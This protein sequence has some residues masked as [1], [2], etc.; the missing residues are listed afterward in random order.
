MKDFLRRRVLHNFGIKLLSLAL[1]VGLLRVDA[2][3]AGAAWMSLL[4]LV[5]ALIG[6][7]IGQML[8]R[9]IASSIFRRVFFAGL[10]LL[11]LYLALQG[12]A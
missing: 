3:H 6:M 9:R 8:R 2:W 4:A 7:Q 10:L 5:P 11:G 12:S 1:A